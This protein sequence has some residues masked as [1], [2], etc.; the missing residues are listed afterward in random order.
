MET[1]NGQN[2]RPFYETTMHFKN[3]NNFSEVPININTPAAPSNLG[4]QVGPVVSSNSKDRVHIFIVYEMERQNNKQRNDFT[5]IFGNK[6]NSSGIYRM[7]GF[8]KLDNAS[9]KRLCIG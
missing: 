7:V 4:T 6:G 9:T 3:E 8:Q 2:N 1:T 5:A